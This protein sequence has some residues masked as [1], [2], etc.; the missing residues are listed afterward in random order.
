MS[1]CPFLEILS[2]KKHKNWI[3][4]KRASWK[5]LFFV[6]SDRPN[7]LLGWSNSHSPGS[8]HEHLNTS[9]AHCAREV[10][11]E[12]FSTVTS[13]PHYNFWHYFWQM[14]LIQFSLGYIL[15]DFRN[16]QMIFIII[17]LDAIL[18]SRVLAKYCLLHYIFAI[19]F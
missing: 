18:Y 14:N 1:Y 11:L 12:L 13:W 16:P 8:S 4:S 3:S 2:F 10:L 17:L 5:F 6:F 7:R 19:R 15:L 9:E